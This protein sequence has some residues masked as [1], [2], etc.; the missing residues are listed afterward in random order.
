[1]YARTPQGTTLRPTQSDKWL[2]VFCDEI[3]LPENDQYG[4]QKVITF[5]RQLTEQRGFWRASDRT[6][7]T[8]H[9]IQ[10]VGA[11]N[12]PTDPGRVPLSPRFL[13]HTPVLLVDFPLPPSLRQIYG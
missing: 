9:N 3:N 7:V 5:L 6:W 4:T 8:L 12:P 1:M 13:R 11:C 2:V 10:F